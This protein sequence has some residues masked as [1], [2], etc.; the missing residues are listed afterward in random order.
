M[1]EDTASVSLSEAAEELI[2]AATLVV[3]TSSQRKDLSSLDAKINTVNQNICQLKDQV[4]NVN[5]SIEHQTKMLESQTKMLESQT[6]M[7]ERQTNLLERQAK[8]QSLEWA[9]QNLV[10]F[11]G[12]SF[13]YFVQSTSG[14][15]DVSES[16]ND[17]KDILVTF[18]QGLGRYINDG[19]MAAY[20]GQSSEKTK[21]EFRD[22]LVNYIYTLTG[23]KPRLKL[24]GNGKYAIYYS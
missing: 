7:L 19:D 6:N 11:E 2:R 9:I 4:T 15:R 21:S 13:R 1:T 24:E 20:Q 18:R 23:V 12:N 22:K 5:A 14:Y 17:V 16:R 8:M 10:L 3:E